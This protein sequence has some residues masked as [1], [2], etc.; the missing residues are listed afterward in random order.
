ME[1]EP[2]GSTSAVVVNESPPVEESFES[3]SDVNKTNEE[4]ASQKVHSKDGLGVKVKRKSKRGRSS[5][6]LTMKGDKI[7]SFTTERGVTYQPNGR[8]FSLFYTCI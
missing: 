1:E 2:A 3:K 5:G 7:T 8:T 6:S 4:S